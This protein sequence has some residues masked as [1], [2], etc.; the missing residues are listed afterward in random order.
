M[1]GWNDFVDWAPC[2]QADATTNGTCA[3]PADDG[4]GLS[5]VAFSFDRGKTW[6]QPTYTGWTASDC[7]PTATCAAHEGPIN[8][9]PWYYENR[10]VSS[11]DPAVAVG[12]IAVNGHFS[13]SNGSRVYYANLTGAW[14]SGFAFPNPEFHGYLAV[15]V[16]RLDNPTPDERPDQVELEAAGDRQQPHR[17]DGV[18]GQGADLGGQCVVEPVL[19]A[20]STSAI[21]SS[22]AM[23]STSASA[24][25]SRL[26]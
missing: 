20:A 18:R 2:P 4:V 19:R 21:R 7:D 25:T 24:G 15:G 11:G 9:L 17:P 1:A 5:A 12:P 13:W 16:S 14:P 8:T 26:R 23:G 6:I 22:A 3:D 10:L